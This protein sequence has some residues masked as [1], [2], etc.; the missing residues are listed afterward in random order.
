MPT[1]DV[2]DVVTG[3]QLL[4]QGNVETSA[5]ISQYT[6]EVW[7]PRARGRP[8]TRVGQFRKFRMDDWPE[9]GNVGEPGHELELENAGLIEKNFF[10][11]YPDLQVL[12]WHS[13]AHANSVNQFSRFVSTVWGTRVS[14]APVLQ[15]E[16]VR[17]LLRGNI[18]LKR[19]T[20]SIPRPRDPDMFPD[21]DF[22]KATL[23]LLN[24]ADGD[25]L[26]LTISI[27]SRR[28]DA[29]PHLARRMKRALAEFA[30]FGA[31]TAKAVVFDD[32]VEHP[33]DLLADRV[34]VSQEAEHDGRYAPEETMYQLIDAARR[35]ANGALREYFGELEN[36]LD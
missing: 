3:F 12:G 21:D 27:D 16:A 35:E 4:E 20:V 36:R 19:L 13:N 22:G 26:N 14:A 9:V 30:E 8:V 6:R 25:S 7:R 1:A 33:I 5:E 28:A 24:A 29:K 2:P 18:D 23:D 10:V 11:F 17:R 31:T 15:P 32:G 34:S